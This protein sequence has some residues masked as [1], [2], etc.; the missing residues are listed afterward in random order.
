LAAV[1]V[2]FVP[3]ADMCSAIGHVRFTPE[4]G[5]SWRHSAALNEWS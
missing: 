2:R 5:H 4:S 1:N 3:K